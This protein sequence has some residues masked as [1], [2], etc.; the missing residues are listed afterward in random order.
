MKISC[1]LNLGVSQNVAIRLR[2][3]GSKAVESWRLF[4]FICYR[5]CI[6][7]VSTY[8]RITSRCQKKYAPES[9]SSAP[10]LIVRN[11]QNPI[12][13]ST[14]SNAS[15]RS[16]SMSP[17]A[18]IL[19]DHLRIRR[20]VWRDYRHPLGRSSSSSIPWHTGGYLRSLNGRKCGHG[21]TGCLELHAGYG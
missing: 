9:C 15:Y 13:S 3:S 17:S 10:S 5:A 8:Q 11:L 14:K 16:F 20:V 19:R 2:A 18:S 6:G 21:S 12:F 4:Y 7:C 1:T